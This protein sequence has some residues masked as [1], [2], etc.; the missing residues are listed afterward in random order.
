MF[1]QRTPANADRKKEISLL[2]QKTCNS[3]ND[4]AVTVGLLMIMMIQLEQHN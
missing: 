3:Y 4:A 2:Y 1:E